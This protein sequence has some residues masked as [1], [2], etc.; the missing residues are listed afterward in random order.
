M[1]ISQSNDHLHGTFTAVAVQQGCGGDS[2][3]PREHL[4][5]L[6]MFLG[7]TVRERWRLSGKGHG[8]TQHPAM[9]RTAPQRNYPAPNVNR[10]EVGKH[11]FKG[12]PG[13]HHA[14]PLVHPLASSLNQGSKV[15]VPTFGLCQTSLKWQHIRLP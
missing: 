5:V 10:A 12:T 1:P 3:L 11:S 6:E 7:L 2:L 15:R 8:S 4:P 13:N 14:F 9:Q